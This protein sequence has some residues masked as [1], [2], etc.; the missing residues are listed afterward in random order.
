ML[1]LAVNQLTGLPD[2]LGNLTALTA[3]YL[4]GNQLTVLPDTRQSHSPDHAGP[5]GNQ[6][7]EVPDTIGELAALTG[8]GLHGNRLHRPARLV[9]ATSPRLPRCT[10]PRTAA[11]AAGLVRRPHR[12]G[13]ADPDRQSDQPPAR[14]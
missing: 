4:G 3:L 14:A 11:R 8:L 1:D 7:T 9:L 2:S 13:R 12:P 10:W 5:G 6:L